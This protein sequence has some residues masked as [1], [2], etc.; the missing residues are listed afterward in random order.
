MTKEVK[1]SSSGN[2]EL[3][4]SH[5][6]ELLTTELTEE[7][8]LRQLELGSIVIPESDIIHL[9][10][11]MS[12]L[13]CVK[14]DKVKT[15]S[16]TELLTSLEQED[17]KLQQLYLTECWIPDEVVENLRKMECFNFILD[18]SEFCLNNNNICLE[19]KKS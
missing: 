17:C 1:L 7:Q 13:P 4:L 11:I 10:A 6:A 12:S 15:Q 9:T 2:M 16:W 3:I 19:R 8:T 14:L 18:E 5:L